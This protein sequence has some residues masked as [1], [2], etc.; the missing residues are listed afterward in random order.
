LDGPGFHV[1]IDVLEAA[2]KSMSEIVA[3]QDNAEL[4]GLCGGAELYG[5]EG[6]HTELAEFCKAWSVGLDALGDR[7]RSMGDKLK[8]AAA[9]YREVDQAAAHGLSKDPGVRAVD[10]PTF[11]GPGH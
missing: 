9:T 10:P 3:D 7:A 5:N 2:A 11:E 4:R 6:V 8:D 1:E